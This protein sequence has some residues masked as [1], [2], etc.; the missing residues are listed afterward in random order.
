M[1]VTAT[2]SPLP[3]YT[4]SLFL[5]SVSFSLS[6]FFSRP[7]FFFFLLSRRSYL[8]R[9]R[10]CPLFFVS[11]PRLLS[12]SSDTFLRRLC[13]SPPAAFLFH[14]PLFSPTPLCPGRCAT[15]LFVVQLFLPEESRFYFSLPALR[16]GRFE[17]VNEMR[18]LRG[19]GVYM[20]IG[21]GGAR[22][23]R[24]ADFRNHCSDCLSISLYSSHSM[25]FVIISSQN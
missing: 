3:M 12:L 8:M 2:A 22:A 16:L 13:P 14:P 5:F 1:T 20:Y 24:F 17:C 21:I 18:K 6:F 9:A 11:K 23:F 19:P 4:P 25:R 15:D 10:R 7:L